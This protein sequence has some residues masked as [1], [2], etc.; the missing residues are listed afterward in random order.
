MIKF[1]TGTM[2]SGKSARLFEEIENCYENY[3]ILK[4][5]LDTRDGAK[6]KTRK[7][8]RTHVA[9]LVDEDNSQIVDLV[10]SGLD[11]YGTVFIDEVQFFSEK[12][13]VELIDVCQILNIDIIASGLT[14]D[15]KGNVFPASRVIVENVTRENYTFLFGECF[16]CGGQSAAFDVLM[17]DLNQILTEGESVQIDGETKDHYESLCQVCYERIKGNDEVLK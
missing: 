12:F 7:H 4:P 16:S 5:S 15:F 10:F 1:I 13:I 14:R 8:D 11:V 9:V 17:N 3:L 6:V 2:N